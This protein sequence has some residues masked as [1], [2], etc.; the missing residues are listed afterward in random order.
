MSHYD[1]MENFYTEEFDPEFDV[2][3][4]DPDTGEELVYETELPFYEEGYDL[5]DW[6]QWEPDPEPNWNDD[7]NG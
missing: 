4:F 3:E 6:Y 2:S 7:Y 5:P 1:N